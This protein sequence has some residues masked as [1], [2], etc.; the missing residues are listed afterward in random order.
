MAATAASAHRN[1]LR[2]YATPKK[3][4]M[5]MTTTTTRIT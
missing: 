1:R 5:K 4:A 3:R 2:P